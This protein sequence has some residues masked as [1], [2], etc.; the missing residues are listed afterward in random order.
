[1]PAF[2]PKPVQLALFYW[3]EDDADYLPMLAE[4]FADG[5]PDEIELAPFAARLAPALTCPSDESAMEA[6]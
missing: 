5:R 3:Q 1:L 6:G 2:K 4:A